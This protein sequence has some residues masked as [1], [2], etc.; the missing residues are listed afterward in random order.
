MKK[1]RGRKPLDVIGNRYGRLVIL[2]DVEDSKPRKVVARCDC[3]TKRDYL[4][5]ALRSGNTKSCGCLSKE[6]ASQAKHKRNGGRKATDLTGQK[7]GKLTAIKRV[8]NSPQNAVARWL[9]R[10]ECGVEKIMYASNLTEGATTSC[11]CSKGGGSTERWTKNQ[12]KDII[13][14]KN[15]GMN[16]EEIS[17]LVNRSLAA[18]AK[19]FS[20][21]RKLKGEKDVKRKTAKKF[22]PSYFKR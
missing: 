13:R 15:S 20:S 12:D 2:K 3:G 16:N 21:L 1:K 19:R 17:K 10:C 4:L 11:G 8:E 7:F 18:L 6:L 22:Y 14:L 5:A 9:C